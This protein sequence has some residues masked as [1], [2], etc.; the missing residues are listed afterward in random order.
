MRNA[1][2]RRSARNLLLAASAAAASL[3]LLPAGVAAATLNVC[4]SGCSYSQ[5]APAL[6]AAHDGDTITLERA[7]TRAASP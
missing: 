7:P 2:L 3:P 5:L 1:S 4:P 6:A